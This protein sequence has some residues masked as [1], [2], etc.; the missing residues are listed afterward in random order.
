MLV[1]KDGGR[2]HVKG[3]FYLEVT[4]WSKM[5]VK[6]GWNK[7]NSTFRAISLLEKYKYPTSRTLFS[8]CLGAPELILILVVKE[9][10]NN[11]YIQVS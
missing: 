8:E 9:V 1:P 3:F 4:Y 7:R 10:L 6:V 5:G 11:T 2:A